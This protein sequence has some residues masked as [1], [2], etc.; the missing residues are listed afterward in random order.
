[1]DVGVIDGSVN[2]IAHGA[3]AIGDASRRTQSGNARSYAVWILIGALVIFVI[4][5]WPLFGPMSRS[6]R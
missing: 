2:G 3:S 6:V 4:I 5:F 1:V